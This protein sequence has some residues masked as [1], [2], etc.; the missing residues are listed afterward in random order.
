MVNLAIDLVPGKKGTNIRQH[1]VDVIHQSSRAIHAT[2]R[3]RYLDVDLVVGH[4]PHCGH[5]PEVRNEWW[6]FFTELLRKVTS[7]GRDIILM[8]DANSR[9]EHA[10]PGIV[11]DYRPEKEDGNTDASIKA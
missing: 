10:F 1:E 11:G 4:A 5:T 3:S 2:V 9:V 8:I 6:K 7:S